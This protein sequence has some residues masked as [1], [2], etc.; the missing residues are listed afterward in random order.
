MFAYPTRVTW[1]PG[2]ALRMGVPGGYRIWHNRG[3]RFWGDLYH[4]CPD[5]LLDELNG[6]SNPDKITALL[7]RY[8]IQKR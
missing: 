8:R 2:G 6:Q 4:Y 1:R 7:K 3:Q 5:D